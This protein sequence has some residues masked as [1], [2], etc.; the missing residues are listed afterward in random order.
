M[1]ER[2]KAKL[3]LGPHGDQRQ[4]LLRDQRAIAEIARGARQDRCAAIIA[5]RGEQICRLIKARHSADFARN[6]H[7]QAIKRQDRAAIVIKGDRAAI[8]M[9][10]CQAGDRL[11]GDAVG[12]RL[13]HRGR[14]K[15]R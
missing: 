1:I 14:A 4:P 10:H 3:G 6:L 15:A 2:T 13:H 8:D 7:G 9:C 12:C 5:Q 11:R